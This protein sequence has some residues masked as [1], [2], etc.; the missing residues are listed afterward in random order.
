GGGGGRPAAPM[1]GD[2]PERAGGG[3]AGRGL[4]HPIKAFEQPLSLV[5]NRPPS[6]PPVSYIYCRRIGPADVFRQFAERA[7]REPDWRYFEIDASHNPHITAPQ[8]LLELLQTIV[9]T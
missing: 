1:P 4:P 3:A 5:G 9:A 2:T 7:Q 6:P 8:A